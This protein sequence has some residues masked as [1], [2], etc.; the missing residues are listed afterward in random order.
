MS[1]YCPKRFRRWFTHVD[2]YL[3]HSLEVPAA[4]HS[5]HRFRHDAHVVAA[6]FAQVWSWVVLSADDPQYWRCEENHCRKPSRHHDAP[7]F[8]AGGDAFAG[9]IN[10]QSAMVGFVTG[11]EG[12]IRSSNEL[13]E[14]G[15]SAKTQYAKC[16]SG[17]SSN[18]SNSMA[19]WPRTALTPR[20]CIPIETPADCS[21]PS[22]RHQTTSIAAPRSS[23]TPE[24]GL[25]NRRFIDSRFQGFPALINPLAGN[26]IVTPPMMSRPNVGR[27]EI[28]SSVCSRISMVPCTDAVVPSK[29]ACNRGWC[30]SAGSVIAWIDIEPSGGRMIWNSLE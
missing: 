30:R 12:E 29:S 7:Q 18:S 27:S 21:K 28:V 1:Y 20:R 16:D 3:N 10:P 5:G 11:G 22:L 2:R 25:T 24:S 8:R 4:R 14:F 17:I 9:E 19:R 13:S 23:K 15:G 6:G 26:Q